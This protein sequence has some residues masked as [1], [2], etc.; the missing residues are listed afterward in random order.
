[1]TYKKVIAIFSAIGA[2]FVVVALALIFE[3]PRLGLHKI[4]MGSFCFDNFDYQDLTNIMFFPGLYIVN[5][6]F[7]DI[8]GGIM[9]II[10]VFNPEAQRSADYALIFAYIVAMIS[11]PILF[12]GIG[13]FSLFLR[14]RSQRRRS[15]DLK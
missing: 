10:K 15:G 3:E 9:F 2:L 14:R 6:Y 1:M 12:G 11:N 5:V 8:V 7:R 4:C 13:A